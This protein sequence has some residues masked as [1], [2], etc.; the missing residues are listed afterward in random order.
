[1]KACFIKNAGRSVDDDNELFRG[2]LVDGR[3][4]HPILSYITA[5]KGKCKEFVMARCMTKKDD[6]A[7]KARYGNIKLLAVGKKDRLLAVYPAVKAG[8]TSISE[9]NRSRVLGFTWIT[10]R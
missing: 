2:D 7:F 8:T 10:K 9:V 6:P 5:K 3:L 1:M 4:T